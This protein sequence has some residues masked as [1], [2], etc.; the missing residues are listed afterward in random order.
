MTAHR[1]TTCNKCSSP[2]AIRTWHETTDAGEVR[3]L[4]R[5][6]VCNAEFESL[7][8]RADAPDELKQSMEVFWPTL[9]VA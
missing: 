3:I 8:G 6:T 2:L 7:E 1:F 5:C 9:L 4:W